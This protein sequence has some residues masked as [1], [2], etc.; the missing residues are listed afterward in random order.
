MLKPPRAEY[1]NT[2]NSSFKVQFLTPESSNSQVLHPNT[3]QL[4]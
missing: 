2:V 4:G 3:K 1:K